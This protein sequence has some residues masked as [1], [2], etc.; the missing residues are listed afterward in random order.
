MNISL[1]RIA[2]SP[3]VHSAKPEKEGF[4]QK[5]ICLAFS[6]RFG[7][8]IGNRPKGGSVGVSPD[9]GVT[10]KLKNGITNKADESGIKRAVQYAHEKHDPVHVKNCVFSELSFHSW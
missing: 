5:Q 10:Y 1:E 4:P 6:G 7:V 8:R 9:T 3:V 2:Y